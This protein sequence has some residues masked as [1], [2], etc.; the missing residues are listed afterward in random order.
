MIKIKFFEET[1]SFI[2]KNT[3]SKIT[4]KK[5][6]EIIKKNNIEIIFN[7][8]DE[9]DYF[10][11]HK[12][13][14]NNNKLIF[15]NNYLN[16]K[17]IFL[18]REDASNVYN[19]LIAKHPN[20]I[21]YIKD[22]TN[23]FNLFTINNNLQFYFCFNHNSKI[24]EQNISTYTMNKIKYN[25]WNIDQYSCCGNQFN[26]R[27][28][29]EIYNKNIDVFAVFHLRDKQLDGIHRKNL[30]DKFILL[31]NKY[32]IYTNH[33]VSYKIYK[34]K[35]EESK[36]VVSPYG[37]GERTATDYNA[38]Y[39]N[40]VLIKP[41]SSYVN[42]DC[43]FFNNYNYYVTCRV[44][45]SDLDYIIDKILNN[46]NYYFNN[47]L[48]AK[49][50]LL[51]INP[52]YH[53]NKFFN[54]IKNCEKLNLYYLNSS[55]PYII[56]E[57][58]TIR[59]ISFTNISNIIFNINDLDYILYND[60]II[61][62]K[63]YDLLNNKNKN[64]IICIPNMYSDIDNLSYDLIENKNMNEFYYKYQVKYLNKKILFPNFDKITYFSSFIC[65]PHYFSDLFND[66][67]FLIIKEM[68][69]GKK[70]LIITTYESFLKNKLLEN[71][72]NITSFI[73]E[74]NFHEK[75]NDVNANIKKIILNEKIET[76]FVMVEKF[77][78]LI[79]SEISNYVK[80][81]DIGKLFGVYNNFIKKK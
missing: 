73:L 13:E 18:G 10:I 74:C 22:Y 2:K 61:S 75:F 24:N 41:Y 50:H 27:E 31:K 53:I 62:N 80:V 72:Q 32:N 8:N 28:K 17:I 64:Y 44:D 23:N 30:Y 47:T 42:C 45:F 25:H 68:F 16:K 29:N 81:V 63:M 78:S 49:E 60:D 36:I 5:L 7:D 70:N 19:E 43:N 34:D 58:E 57:K 3:F 15:E 65:Y 55:F 20:V 6:F 33:D 26:Y 66:D 4:K 38:I 14:Y 9:Y 76:C 51:M 46:Y 39:N 69:I 35:I 59:F 37:M 77:S 40:C 79:S 71:T 12:Y 52:E 56:N 21:I 67:F 11:T 54:L 1:Y 48:K